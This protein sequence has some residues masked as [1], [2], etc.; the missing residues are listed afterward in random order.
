MDD[1]SSQRPKIVRGI[2]ILGM[3]NVGWFGILLLANLLLYIFLT[4]EPQLF[5]TITEL[6]RSR[7]IE[8]TFTY[9]IVKAAILIQM[10]ICF[11]YVISGVGILKRK[12]WGRKFTVCFA[13]IYVFVLFV[14]TVLQPP[15]VKYTLFR[16]IYP[17]ILIWYFTSKKI[18]SNF[19]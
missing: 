16:I 10:I 12:N 11:L 17:G 6:I 14:L 4:I 19:S 15:I 7:G 9:T 2:L 3:I 18:I 8:A 5:E 1:T 13:S